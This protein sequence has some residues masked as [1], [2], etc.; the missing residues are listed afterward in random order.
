MS[1][2]GQ[3]STTEVPKEETVEELLRMVQIVLEDERMRGQN[4]DGKSSTLAGFTGAIL[5]LTVGL[6]QRFHTTDFGDVGDFVVRS[7]SILSTL[8]LGAAAALAIGG[9]LRPQGRLLISRRQLKEFAKRPLITT[10]RVEIQGRMIETLTGALQRER[11]VNDRKAKLTR[12]AALAL[13]GGLMGL[14]AEGIAITIA[15]WS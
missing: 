13:V 7:L 4:L 10:P 15:S 5:A 2:P 1:D 6:G 14:V 9:V 11:E 3:K 12:Y 8:A